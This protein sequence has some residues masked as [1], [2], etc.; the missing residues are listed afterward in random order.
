M[1]LIYYSLPVAVLGL[2]QTTYEVDEYAGIID[3]C[4]EIL[5]T[6]LMCTVSSPF[7]ITF[8]TSDITG[9]TIAS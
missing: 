4:V 7:T 8:T 9:N 3:V 6:S 1:Y 2:Q 5:T